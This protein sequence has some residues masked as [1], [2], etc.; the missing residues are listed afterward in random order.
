MFV[1]ASGRKERHDLTSRGLM[2][3]AAGRVETTDRGA[4]LK[5][6][7]LELTSAGTGAAS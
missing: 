2:I 7:V 6:V 5:R 3:S 1:Y 4:D